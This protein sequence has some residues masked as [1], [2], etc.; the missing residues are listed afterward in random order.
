M[1]KRINNKEYYTFSFLEYEIKGTGLAGK[2]QAILIQCL[3]E[4][5]VKVLKGGGPGRF[6]KDVLI[7]WLWNP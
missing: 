1:L 7:A 3:G 4:M 5:V 6:T 2:Q